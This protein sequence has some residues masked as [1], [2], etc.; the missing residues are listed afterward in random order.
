MKNKRTFER[1]ADAEEPLETIPTKRHAKQRP[2]MDRKTYDVVMSAFDQ[3]AEN[4]LEKLNH[5]VAGN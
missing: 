1:D 2:V 5:S 4:L 3:A